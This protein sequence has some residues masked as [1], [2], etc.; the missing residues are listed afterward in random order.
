ME[1]A[2]KCCSE[3]HREQ[4][5]EIEKLGASYLSGEPWLD[6]N[7]SVCSDRIKECQDKLQQCELGHLGD[8]Y[9]K[10]G[11]KRRLATATT[12]FNAAKLVTLLTT[13]HNVDDEKLIIT[14]KMHAHDTYKND[15]N[16]R[17]RANNTIDGTRVD[18]LVTE[19]VRVASTSLFFGRRDKPDPIIEAIKH[20]YNANKHVVSH[21]EMADKIRAICEARRK[22][23][24]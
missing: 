11:W 17:N 18:T 8:I 1:A 19:A 14:F 20:S 21:Q 10:Y 15:P 22:P 6:E 9:T 3:R 13:T 23:N 5:K 2:I 24:R 7:G 12:E 16:E 4:A